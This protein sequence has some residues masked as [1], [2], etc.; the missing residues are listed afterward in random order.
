MWTEIRADEISRE[1]ASKSTRNQTKAAY[2]LVPY[3]S[4]CKDEKE[5]HAFGTCGHSSSQRGEAE[6]QKSKPVPR[7]SGERAGARSGAPAGL[8]IPSVIRSQQRA[9]Q[10][11]RLASNQNQVSECPWDMDVGDRLVTATQISFLPLHIL[12]KQ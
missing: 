3:H 11:A 5:T 12:T 2:S 6:K 4:G 7:E 8:R 9:R 10:K 1:C